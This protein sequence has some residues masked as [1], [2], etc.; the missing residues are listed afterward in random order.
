MPLLRNQYFDLK[1]G[2][3]GEKLFSKYFNNNY[4]N[5]IVKTKNKFE[6]Y[7]FDVYDDDEKVGYWELKTRRI[8]SDTYNSLMFG[9]NK[10]QKI[11][12]HQDKLSCR[13]YF[14][15]FDKLMYWECYDV[16][17]KQN[18]E[19]FI[20]KNVWLEERQQYIDCVCVKKEYLQ[21][22]TDTINSKMCMNGIE[23]RKSITKI[24]AQEER[25]RAYYE[26]QQR[27]QDSL[28]LTDSEDEE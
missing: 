24:K 9:L 22:E 19:W 15:C 8:K 7:D 11:E 14:L 26:Q 27:Q 4:E 6:E 18:K 2:A 10:L 23:I 1:L 21:E 12:K 13:I 16:R 17:G 25:M 3:R 5:K 28:F 20:K